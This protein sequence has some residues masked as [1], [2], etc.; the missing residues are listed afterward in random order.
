ML[1]INYS[2]LKLII[3]PPKEAQKGQQQFRHGQVIS[4]T[5]N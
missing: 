4:W 5:R 1:E 2:Y 3:H